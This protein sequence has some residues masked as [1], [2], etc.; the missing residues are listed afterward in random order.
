MN[1]III[2]YYKIVIKDHKLELSKNKKYIIRQN[3]SAPII[4]EFQFYCKKKETF[5]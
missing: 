5:L 4:F 1:I 2:I 3:F